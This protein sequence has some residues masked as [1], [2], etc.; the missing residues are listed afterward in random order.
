MKLM[1]RLRT[2]G[3]GIAILLIVCLALSYLARFGYIAVK[4]RLYAV[5]PEFFLPI[6]DLPEEAKH[7]IFL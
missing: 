7:L 2:Y 4:W 6:R 1:T 3:L 5:S